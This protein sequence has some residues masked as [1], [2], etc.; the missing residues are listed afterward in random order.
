MNENILQIIA[1]LK[2]IWIAVFSYFYGEGGIQNKWIRRFIA[3]VWFAL[4]I[5]GFSMW[6]GNLHLLKFLSPA[7]LIG[8]LHMGYGG[9]KTLIKFEKRAL[10]GFLIGLSSLPLAFTSHLWV[11]FGIQILLCILAS[12]LFGVLNPFKNAR[13]EET[14]IA[15]F[16]LILPMFMI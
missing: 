16:S 14:N 5:Y 2:I 4:G 13:D 10:Y 3:A 11:L 15:T 12:V 9:D 6:E 7:L 1:S 8:A